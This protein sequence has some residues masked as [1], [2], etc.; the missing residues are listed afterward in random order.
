MKIPA[1]FFFV[2]FF[3][4][5]VLAKNPAL[6]TKEKN[7]EVKL[8]ISSILDEI[9]NNKTETGITD[10]IEKFKIIIMDSEFN[11]ISVESVEK[12]E[13]IYNQ[14]TLVPII[15]RSE[16]ITKIHNISYYILQKK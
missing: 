2:C 12:V 5:S 8:E 7:T 6:E 14:S 10:P 16:F 11:K 15:Y 1:I 9:F 13:D 4:I 3:C